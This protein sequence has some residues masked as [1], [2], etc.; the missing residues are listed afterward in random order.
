[1][2]IFGLLQ[3]QYLK[4]PERMV[5]MVK[6][7][8]E[9]SREVFTKHALFAG[10]KTGQNLTRIFGP[11]AKTW[12]WVNCTPQIGRTTS[13]RFPTDLDYIIGKLEH[14]QPDIIM[15]FGGQARDAMRRIKTD[16]PVIFTVHPVNWD[17]GS[18]DRL[19]TAR[20]E[21]DRLKETFDGQ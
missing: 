6:R 7:Y 4:N 2:I 14:Y 12:I 8:G 17:H 3:N 20:N 19:Y 1:M 15:A 5:D 18:T 9:D 13:E 11:E 21:L 10:C 16:V